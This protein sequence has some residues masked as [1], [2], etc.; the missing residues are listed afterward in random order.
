MNG[1]P[2]ALRLPPALKARIWR[3]AA[4]RGITRTGWVVHLIERGL[5]TDS[6]EQFLAKVGQSEQPAP[7]RAAAVP[8]IVL[9]RV[10]FAV[11]FAEALLKKLNASLN[12]S[13]SELGSVAAQAR[14]Q[15]RAETVTLLKALQG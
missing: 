15:A 8:P 6:L 1:N 5:L 4:E 12:R 10:L 7:G 3:D 14:D 9:E 13:T 2:I 11:C